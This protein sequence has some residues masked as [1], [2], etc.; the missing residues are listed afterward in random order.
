MDAEGGVVLA[1]VAA[2]VPP[3]LV[4]CAAVVVGDEGHALKVPD[5]RRVAD[6]TCAAVGQS[7][8]D[9]ALRQDRRRT[10]RAPKVRQALET[11]IY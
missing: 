8:I 6:V 11:P 5:E 7:L 10:E 4:P 2:S 3:Y 9:P 1:F